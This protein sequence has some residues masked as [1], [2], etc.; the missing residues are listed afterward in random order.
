MKT[1]PRVSLEKSSSFCSR[2][3]WLSV[4]DTYAGDMKDCRLCGPI[5]GS[6]RQHNPSTRRIP[7]RSSQRIGQTLPRLVPEDRALGNP[8]QLVRSPLALPRTHLPLQRALQ[9]RALPRARRRLLRLRQIRPRRA[10]RRI[11]LPMQLHLQRQRIL[12]L[13]TSRQ[14]MI[15]TR[16]QL[17]PAR[18]RNP[19]NLRPPRS[20]LRKLVA[21]PSRQLP[22]PSIRYPKPKNISTAGVGSGRTAIEA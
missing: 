12:P 9:Q 7:R 2:W 18:V 4:S 6:H 8:H 10:L 1:S 17:L 21:H 16:L 14:L 11:N 13:P 3:P 5:S 19:P 22:S 20:L 15:P